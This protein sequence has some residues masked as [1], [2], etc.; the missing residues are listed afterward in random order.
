MANK[1]SDCPDNAGDLGFFPRGKMVPE[2]EDEVFSMNP[3]EISD[4]F[5]TPFGYHIAKVYD[6]KQGEDMAAEEAKKR[7]KQELMNR[8]KSQ[9]IEEYADELWEKAEIQ[10]I[11]E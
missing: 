6:K 8:K 10:E 4:V 1:H 5:L 3:G 2:F 11:Q 9:K 7:I